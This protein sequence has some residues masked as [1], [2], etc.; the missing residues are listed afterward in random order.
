MKFDSK[1]KSR[2]RYSK[3]LRAKTLDL[4]SKIRQRRRV[5]AAAPQSPGGTDTEAGRIATAAETGRRLLSSEP[6]L[7]PSTAAG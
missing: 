1:T 7:L 6:S 4:E 3:M 5:L 2:I